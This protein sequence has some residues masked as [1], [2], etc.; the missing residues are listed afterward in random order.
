MYCIRCGKKLEDGTK[1]CTRCGAPTRVN[2]GTDAAPAAE[3]DL[4][5]TVLIPQ[6]EMQAEAA[7]SIQQ[8]ME[9]A[10]APSAAVE[11]GF[12]RAMAREKIIEAM[13]DDTAA[14]QSEQTH[15]EQEEQTKETEQTVAETAAPQPDQAGE[16]DY[17]QM[18]PKEE[19]RAA[20]QQEEA[21]DEP[22]EPPVDVEAIPDIPIPQDYIA[23]EAPR[24]YVP[25]A[26]YVPAEHEVHRLQQ[27]DNE[28]LM[29]K[30]GLLF[31]VLVVLLFFAIAVGAFV[32]ALNSTGTQDA[33][34][35]S[36]A[37][38]LWPADE[39]V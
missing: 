33:G 3:Q 19:L 8:V 32:L 13:Q 1:Y 9:Q 2:R 21:D 31:V 23:Q 6:D 10:A 5:Q 15:A 38:G 12:T 14:P 4:E 22:E 11:E 16:E 27:E 20:L 26:P 34:S 18:I 28:P 35:G 36:A 17:T 24:Y 25:P 37:V 7:Q 30:R 29:S 39:T